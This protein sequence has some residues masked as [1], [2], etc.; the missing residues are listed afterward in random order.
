MF[1]MCSNRLM[2]SRFSIDLAELRQRIVI[3]LAVAP[4]HLFERLWRPKTTPEER[5]LVRFD[6]VAHI[7][8][9]WASAELT[10][11]A[12]IQAGHDAS[13]TRAAERD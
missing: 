2:D 3:R 7:T 13:A 9:G 8:E 5:D 4:R 6:L 1:L 10:G 11:S 12:R